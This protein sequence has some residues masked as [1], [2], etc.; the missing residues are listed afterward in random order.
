MDREQEFSDVYLQYKELVWGVVSRYFAQQADREEAFQETFIRI[1]R[2]LPS[3]KKDQPDNFKSWIYKVTASTSI[4]LYNQVKRKKMLVDGLKNVQKFWT[5]DQLEEAEYED[6]YI[7]KMLQPLSAEQRAALILREVNGLSYEQIAESM[8]LK[9]GTVKSMLNRAK[10]KVK[11]YLE[12][13]DHHE[14]TGS[15][16]RSH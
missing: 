14:C 7:D 1:Y 5:D 8:D 3:L 10:Q 13:S 2:Y 15:I 9:L 6:N 4:N 11:D 16:Y 12:R